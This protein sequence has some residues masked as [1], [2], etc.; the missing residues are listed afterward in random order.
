[1][2]GRRRLT[3]I[4]LIVLMLAACNAE[5]TPASPLGCQNLDAGYRLRL[6]DGWWVHP[7]DDA[8][9]IAPCSRFGPGPF[10]M[11]ER[12][13]LPAGESVS[14][15][16]HN[17]CLGREAPPV[18][19]EL[20]VIDGFQAHRARHERFREFYWYVIELRGGDPHTDPCD[21]S[22]WAAVRTN[23]DDPGDYET[24]MRAVDA[25][26]SSIDFKPW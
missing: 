8:R 21:D 20:V 22:V 18:V 16:V 6:P 3:G 7:E 15:T 24:N 26:A 11:V 25:I 17:I 9:G 12:N 19:D 23:R 13:G 10:E 2:S 5:A 14:V 1:V 4:L